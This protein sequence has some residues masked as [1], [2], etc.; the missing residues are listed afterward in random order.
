MTRT[1]GRGA[2]TGA[3]RLNGLWPRPLPVIMGVLNCTPDSFSD[4][5]RFLRLDH[6]V[7]HGLQLLNDGADILDVGGEST[8]PGATAVSPEE[9]LERIIPVIETLRRERPGA[10]ISV[11]TT[12][13]EVAEAALSSGA[14]LVNDVTAG[15][16]PGMLETVSRAGAGII[17]MHMRGTPRT[18][19][20]ETR[21][22][23]VV[24]EVT[25]FLRNRLQAAMSA[26]IPPSS[27]W[28]DP[29]IGFGKDAA[30]NLALLAA[31]PELA[32][33]G[34]PVVVGPSRKSFI[35]RMTGAEP[36][37]RLP[38]TLAAL[39]PA[40]SCPRSVVRVH[41]PAPALQFLTV[42]RGIQEAN[43]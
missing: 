8:R 1:N 22:H 31:L 23:H 19:Q 26:G 2:S 9:E 29:G 18:M 14:D 12:K 13:P 43:P 34:H 37:H 16:A 42:A 36:E 5:G 28:L 21:Y 38:G 6:A 10:V 4:G 7:A 17:L 40:L 20:A 30:G 15:T 32:T 35:G 11:D 41:D 3:G 39:A 24:A 33:L 25:Q 27:V